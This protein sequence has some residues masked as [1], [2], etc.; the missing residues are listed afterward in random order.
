VWLGF[1]SKMSRWSEPG[2]ALRNAYQAEGAA[3]EALGDQ[4]F[5]RFQQRFDFVA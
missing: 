3:L 5:G 4:W 1:T 2:G